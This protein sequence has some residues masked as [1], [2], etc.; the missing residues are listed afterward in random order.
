[1]EKDNQQENTQRPLSG[2]R[3]AGANSGALAAP[4]YTTDD[5][6]LAIKASIDDTKN[7]YYPLRQSFILN[8]DILSF[9]GM[10]AEI[11][12]SAPDSPMPVLSQ[13]D[14]T[15]F[16]SGFTYEGRL[17]SVSRARLGAAL[18]QRPARS[19]YFP[20]AIP[21]SRLLIIDVAIVYYPLEPDSPEQQALQQALIQAM[22]W[23]KHADAVNTPNGGKI[24]PAMIRFLVTL[25][26]GNRILVEAMCNPLPALDAD[27]HPLS[28]YFAR[29][30]FLLKN[31]NYRNSADVG[32]SVENPIDNDPGPSKT[33]ASD[34]NLPSSMPEPSAEDRQVNAQARAEAA[35]KVG[36]DIGEPINKDGNHWETRLKEL[37]EKVKARPRA[38]GRYRFD[39]G[40]KKLLHKLWEEAKAAGKSLPYFLQK[41]NDYTEEG[42]IES[43]FRGWSHNI[44]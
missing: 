1:M 41:V 33:V 25:F 36:M 3:D 19:V 20:A 32:S 4:Y 17:Y 42:V 7:S 13:N 21:V 43:T 5:L 34:A 16:R 39:Y 35:A 11:M 40:E 30:I 6:L 12:V 28:D 26:S 31:A 23:Q 2:N 27:P 10:L 44:E 14:S 29:L 37:G 38:G 9:E 8:T 15:Y 18:I 24:M 22:G